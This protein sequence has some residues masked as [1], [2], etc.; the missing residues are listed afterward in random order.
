MTQTKDF[1]DWN[2]ELVFKY[3]VA[4]RQMSNLN[5]EQLLEIALELLYLYHFQTHT[6]RFITKAGGYPLDLPTG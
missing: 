6:V 2:P 1:T 5:H 4:K 3:E